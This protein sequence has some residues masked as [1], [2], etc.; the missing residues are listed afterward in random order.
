MNRL[1]TETRGGKQSRMADYQ[2]RMDFVILDE[3]GYLPL[4]QSG[5][6][7]LLRLISRL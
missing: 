5:S 1:E 7:L 3:L 4:A 2:T 6:Q